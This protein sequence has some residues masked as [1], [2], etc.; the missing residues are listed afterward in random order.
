MIPFVQI[1]RNC[2]L[3]V[4][5]WQTNLSELPNRLLWLE[6]RFRFHIHSGIGHQV[7]C[8]MLSEGLGQWLQHLHGELVEQHGGLVGSGGLE[9]FG[10]ATKQLRH[11]LR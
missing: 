10:M 3:W 7:R 4:Q 2:I 1:F 9:F 8:L 6:F 11:I 5:V